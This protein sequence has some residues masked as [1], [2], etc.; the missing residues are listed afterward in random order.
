MVISLIGHYIKQSE[1]SRPQICQMFE[2]S[3]NTLSNWC[4]AKTFPTIPQAIKLAKV[5][6]CKIDDLYEYRG[7]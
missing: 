5:L 3:N 1:Y 2:I 7:E 4:T 6:G